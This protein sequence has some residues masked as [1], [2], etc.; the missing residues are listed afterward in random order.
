MCNVFFVCL[1]F[2]SVLNHFESYLKVFK[3]KLQRE[4]HDSTMHR[5][6]GLNKTKINNKTRNTLT[7]WDRAHHNML[8]NEN[9]K[10]NY[11]EKNEIRRFFHLLSNRATVAAATTITI[12]TI[13]IIVWGVCAS[14]SI[15][16]LCV[17]ICVCVCVCVFLCVCSVSKNRCFFRDWLHVERLNGWSSNKIYVP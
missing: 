6:N 10:K 3:K 4:N 14:H 2:S 13:M 5:Q 12:I 7:S 16:I 17:L 9:R 15:H 8:N 1:F 11:D